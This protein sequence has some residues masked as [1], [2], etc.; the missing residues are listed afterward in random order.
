MFW[1][2]KIF[3]REVRLI[4]LIQGTYLCDDDEPFCWR[5]TTRLGYCT[6][7]KFQIVIRPERRLMITLLIATATLFKTSDTMDFVDTLEVFLGKLFTKPPGT[8]AVE[9]NKKKKII[10]NEAKEDGIAY[11]T[12]QD[13]NKEG[14]MFSW[15]THQVTHQVT[16]PVTQQA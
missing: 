15:V 4:R 8:E 12:G 11:Q 5:D 3:L 9:K 6:V 2:D 16:H 14:N 10:I 13:P 1:L 7:F